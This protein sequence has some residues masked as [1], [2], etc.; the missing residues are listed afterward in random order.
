MSKKYDQN[1]VIES[2]EVFSFEVF[3]GDVGKEIF[4]Y[5]TLFRLI[6]VSDFHLNNP[7]LEVFVRLILYPS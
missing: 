3:N 2:N 5:N 7:E 6:D 1:N 4:R